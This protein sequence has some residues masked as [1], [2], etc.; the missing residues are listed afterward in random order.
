MLQLRRNSLFCLQPNRKRQ[1][2]TSSSRQ[3]LKTTSLQ[4]RDNTVNTR[5]A[6]FQLGKNNRKALRVSFK[7]SKKQKTKTNSEHAELL[8]R[9][10]V[11]ETLKT[12]RGV[13]PGTLSPRN[14]CLTFHRARLQTVWG[15]RTKTDTSLSRSLLHW[16]PGHMLH[17]LTPRGFSLLTAVGGGP[18]GSWP[19]TFDSL[20]LL[21]RPHQSRL[22]CQM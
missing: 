20:S 12:K 1:L 11:V 17:R 7:S 2:F 8:A 14:C 13:N 10:P 19:T 9:G 21:S 18:E 3:G 4:I 6:Y 16:P 15:P 22:T 5:G